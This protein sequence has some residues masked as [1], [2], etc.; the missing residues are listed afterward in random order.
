MH[1]YK[2]LDEDRTM[3]YMCLSSDDESLSF[4]CIQQKVTLLM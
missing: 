2:Y 4:Q 1:I 3:T